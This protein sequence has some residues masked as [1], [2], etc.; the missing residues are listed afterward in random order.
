MQPS[1]E[2]I[3]EGKRASVQLYFNTAASH[4]RTFFPD[5]WYEGKDGINIDNMPVSWTAT[6]GNG[7]GWGL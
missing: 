2:V 1:G 6:H 7:Y 5:C 4:G 3:V